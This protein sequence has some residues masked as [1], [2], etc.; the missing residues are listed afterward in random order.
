MKIIDSYDKLPLGVYLDI[1]ALVED[2]DLEEDDRQLSIIA[3]L[4]G[5][6]EDTLLK[7]PIL[8]FRRLAEKARFLEEQVP[9][10]AAVPKVIRLGGID[11]VPTT[12]VTKITTAQFVDYQTFAKEGHK[13]LVEQLSCFLIPSGCEYNEGYDI[14]DVQTAIRDNLTVTQAQ[15]LAAFFFSRWTRLVGSSLI[16]SALMARRI[17][18]KA[19]R[20]E[21]QAQIRQAWEAF[22]KNGDG[23]TAF[24]L[25]VIPPI[26]RGTRYGE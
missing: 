21:M 4:T 23:S 13:R 9:R 19:K 5:E 22:K 20:R 8:D 14:E 24:A 2:T 17:R 15:G 7:L 12:K 16:Y 6:D 26:R 18:P 25:S 10:P 1:V 3:L 11:L